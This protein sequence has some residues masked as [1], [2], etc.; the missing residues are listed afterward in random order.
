MNEIPVKNT[1]KTVANLTKLRL[2]L[3]L[4]LL[5]TSYLSTF[6]I[7]PEKYYSAFL[8][9]GTETGASL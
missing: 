9:Q 1:D 5:N 8:L 6:S 4:F 3:N 7:L 2:K